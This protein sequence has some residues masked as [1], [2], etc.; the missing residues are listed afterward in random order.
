[1][2]MKQ[3]KPSTNLENLDLSLEQVYLIRGRPF[4]PY[5]YNLLNECIL[6]QRKFFIL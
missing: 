4:E 5:F 1:M 2:V 6:S 3:L